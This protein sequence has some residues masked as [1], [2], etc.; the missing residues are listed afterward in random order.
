VHRGHHLLA[1]ILAAA[2]ASIALSACDAGVPPPT[3]PVRA[4][5][6]GAPRDVNVILKDWVFLPDPIDLVPGE[7]VLF[8]VVN[9]GLEVHELVIGVPAVQDAWEAAEAANA[10]PPPGPTPVVS[11]S[12]AVAGVRVVVASGQRVDV[13]WTVPDAAATASLILGCHIPGH[14][15]KGMRAGVRIAASGG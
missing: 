7:T 11:V 9:G 12:P 4:G 2:V 5:S 10:D 1:I 8:H 13:A 15:A 3:P 6:P 14:W